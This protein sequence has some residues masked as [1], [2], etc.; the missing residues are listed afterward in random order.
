VVSDQ[1]I[2]FVAKLAELRAKKEGTLPPPV[3]QPTET[4]WKQDDLLP[5][6]GGNIS[7][8][9]R[10]LDAFV[11]GIDIIDAYNK[12]CRKMTPDP[13]GKRE[14]IMISCPNPSHPDK[15]P[16]AWINL[17]KQTYFCGGC[18]EGG[19]A[20]DIAAYAYGL[21]VPGYKTGETF[22]KLRKDMA[23][24]FG[25]R[26]KKVPG[27][28]VTWV[29]PPQGSPPPPPPTPI[30]GAVPPQVVSPPHLTVVPEP[31]VDADGG[32]IPEDDDVSH[33]WADDDGTDDLVH[34]P[35]IDWKNL[36]P[37]DTFIYEYMKATSNDDSPEEYHFWHALMALG[38]VV[39]RNVTLDDTRPVYGNLLLC[40]LGATGTGKSRSRGHLDRCLRE[41]APFHADGTRTTGVKLVPVPSSGEYLVNSF[42]YEG[43]DP[44]NNKT[45]LG[46][47]RVAGL[48]DFDEM[49][50]LLARANRQGSTL[51]STIMGFADAANEVKIGGLQ[52]GDFIAHEPFCSI[53]ASTQPK[54]IRT[55]LSRNDT[56]SGF[57]NRWIFAGGKTKQIE[58]L[59]GSR[60][61]IRIDLTRAIEELK[62][63]RGWGAL[64]R[65]IEMEDDAY[66]AFS[67]FF[68]NKI[69]PIKTKD[70]TDLLKRIDLIAKKL[71]LLLTINRRETKVKADTVKVVS[72]LIEY[73]VECY[74]ILNDNIGVTLMQDVMNELQRHIARHQG[75]TGRGASVR[76]IARYTARKNYSLEQIKKALDV[77]TALDLIE[78]EPKASGVGRPTMRYRVVGE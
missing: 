63:V 13:G 23:E 32:V 48:V 16:S 17:D 75:K 3:P 65:S 22:H 52:R 47:Q 36:I 20:H 67:Y 39:G 38:L 1:P 57:L 19:D 2:D 53:T 33:M 59:G 24:A 77:M 4:Q 15:V 18:Q 41:V 49:S 37:E 60:S 54:A 10:E 43:K 56:G 46:P 5:D 76:D 21:P 50:A 71:M 62:A 11:D 44:S 69:E 8:A 27:G 34:Y 6:L 14:S 7:E 61:D 73:V 28:T 45:S 55:L 31:Q 66:E 25:F 51:K 58:V 12:W 35:T 30:N 29:E 74:G 78:L 68:R 72:H 40:I 64:E 26:S 70:Q 42:F 9:D